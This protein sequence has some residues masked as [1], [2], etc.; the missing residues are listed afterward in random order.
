MI[1]LL[2]LG[3][4]DN[5]KITI[6]IVVGAVLSDVGMF[7]FYL[8]QLALGTTE[9]I[10]WSVEYYRPVWQAIFDL[11]HSIPLALLG[12]LISWKSG[13]PWLLVFFAS[14][15]L[16]ALGDLPL[17]HDDAHRHFFPLFDWRFFSPVSYWNSAYYGNWASLV[18]CFAVI[19]AGIY[20]Y[21]KQP[22]LKFWIAGIGSTYFV[23]WIYV[24]NVWV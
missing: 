10:I 6:F 21:L 12:M 5:R 19:S 15:L 16:H 14:I 1:N 24:F 20:L 3:R 4:R 23:Y 11:L 8:W 9:S 18:E 22:R 13:R 2:I 17:H 7:V